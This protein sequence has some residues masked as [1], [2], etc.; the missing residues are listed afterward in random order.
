MECQSRR[1]IHIKQRKGKI[2]PQKHYKQ[3]P[4]NML[5]LHVSLQNKMW[6]DLTERVSLV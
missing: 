5:R 4:H 3:N 1:G 6:E 2:L